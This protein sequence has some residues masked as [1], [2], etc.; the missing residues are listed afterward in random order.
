MILNNY[1]ISIVTH[2]LSS[3]T[4]I[5]IKCQLLGDVKMTRKSK[6]NKNDTS[7]IVYLEVYNNSN[8]FTPIQ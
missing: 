2:K 6:L 4:E 8:L 7:D 5:K 3:I 1:Y